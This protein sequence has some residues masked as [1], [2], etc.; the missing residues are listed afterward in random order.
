M[1]C[2]A[3]LILILLVLFY[4]NKLSGLFEGFSSRKEKADAIYKW[5]KSGG[6]SYNSYREDIESADIIEYHDVKNAISKGAKSA[7]DFLHAV[8]SY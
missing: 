6:N 2:C 3:V 5:H 4:W 7:D 1:I 8:Y